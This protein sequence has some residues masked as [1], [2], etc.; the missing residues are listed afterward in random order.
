MLRPKQ[1]LGQNFL[2]DENIVRKIIKAIDVKRED[3]IVEIGPGR[4]A[5]TKHLMHLTD[6]FIAVEIDGRVCEH[7]KNE[8]GTGLRIV[9]EDFLETDLEVI[10]CKY[11][12]KIRLV[13]NIPYHI[14]SPILF[15]V[16]ER[17]SLVKD[18]MIM[19][20]LEV[21]RRIVAKPRTKEYGIL[22]VL[23]QF[24]DTPEL[25]FKVSPSCFYPKPKVTSA[26]MR[27]GFSRSLKYRVRDE[28]IFAQVVKATFGKRRKTIRNGLKSMSLPDFDLEAVNFDL[29]LRPEDLSV[30]DFVTL[31]NLIGVPSK[32]SPEGSLS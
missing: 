19:M 5:L 22:S 28:S 23:C 9:H 7:L 11:Q 18:M 16:M 29:N 15:K 10:C 8:Y 2:V 31:A 14:T 30:A 17:R 25:L 1:S 4:G 20:Q 21:A 24:Y 6:N 27:F 13:G 3:V 12:K 32:H 26:M